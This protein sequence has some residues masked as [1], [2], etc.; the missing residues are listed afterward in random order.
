MKNGKLGLGKKSDYGRCAVASCFLVSKA[1]LIGDIIFWIYQTVQLVLTLA[2]TDLLIISTLLMIIYQKPH[3]VN[4][5]CK[6][7]LSSQQYQYLSSHPSSLFDFFFFCLFQALMKCFR[8]EFKTSDIYCQNKI[9]TPLITKYHTKFLAQTLHW[10]WIKGMFSSF[11]WQVSLRRFLHIIWTCFN[12][13]VSSSFL[14][15]VNT[16]SSQC[17]KQCD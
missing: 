9:V 10:I 16:E 17:M 3:S 8:G 6:W 4:I 13:C 15:N 14:H 5:L 2:I 7:Q 11:L 1:V 12:Q